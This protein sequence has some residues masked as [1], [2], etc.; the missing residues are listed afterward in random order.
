MERSG[1]ILGQYWDNTGTANPTAQVPRSSDPLPCPPLAPRRPPVPIAPIAQQLSGTGRRR[2]SPGPAIHHL[3]L[4]T[5]NCQRTNAPPLGELS[6]M[7]PEKYTFVNINLGR[8][9]RL[10]ICTNPSSCQFDI[11]RPVGVQAS[12]CSVSVFAPLSHTDPLGLVPRVKQFEQLD[13]IAPHPF[14][15]HEFTR[16]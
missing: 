11:R 6:S 4:R 2:T 13:H 7:L 16:G 10:S 1:T 3:N 12:A 5:P 15:P 14:D 8:G 9:Q